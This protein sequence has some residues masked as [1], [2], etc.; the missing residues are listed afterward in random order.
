[1]K[2]KKIKKMLV[3]GT[4][5]LML[6]FTLAGCGASK[7]SSD[8]IAE[9]YDYDPAKV[10]PSDT[11]QIAVLQGS[12]YDMG[13]QLGEQFKDEVIA[14]T[15]YLVSGQIDT[16]GSYDAAVEAFQPYLEEADKHFTHEKDGGLT[17]MIQGT[18]DSTGMSFDDTMMLYIDAASDIPANTPSG[19]G[20]GKTKEDDQ[21]DCSATMIWGN[22]TATDEEGCIGSMK[23]DIG[24]GDLNFMPTMLMIPDNGNAFIST[25]GVFGSAV[26]EKG[27][28]VQSPGGSVV[29]YDEVY[30]VGIYPSMYL[31]AYCDTTKEAIKVLGDPETT[32]RE[33]WW[34]IGTDFNMILG[35][36]KGDACVFEISGSERNIRYNGE[37]KYVGKTDAG[38]A[39]VANETADYLCAANY[40]MSDNMLFTSRVNPQVGLDEAWPDGLVRYWSLEKHIQ[41]AVA[42]GGADEEILRKAMSSYSYYIP[43]GWDY[44]AYPD[45]GYYGVIVP[46]DIYEGFADGSI[47][48]ED[49]YGKS[50][51]PEMWGEAM[52]LEESR[53]AEDW[54]AGWHDNLNGEWTWNLDT[55]YWAP[56]PVTPDNKTGLINIFDSNSKTLY[57]QKGS[58]DR[59]LSNIPD[60]TGTFAALQFADKETVKEYDGDKA[61]A[62]LGSMQYEL[63]EQLWFAARDLTERGVDPDTA[64]GKIQYGYLEDAKEM[65]YKAQSYASLGNIAKDENEKLS[66]YSKAMSEYVKGQCYAKMAQTDSATLYKDYGKEEPSYR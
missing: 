23:A 39:V 18:A 37:T 50:Y 7:G 5:A 9:R 22:A 29:N 44:D 14:S 63:E 53:A 42:D 56:E 1:M 45:Y 33:D 47:S 20:E 26:N 30:R 11:S 28:M 46:S 49:Y 36:A 17:D 3:C 25:H 60:S 4:T 34:P 65:I 48:R 61:A 12:W 64:T 8:E 27:F 10:T 62:M 55:S 66:Y 2:N 6:G 58:S 40:Y 54:S 15:V 41:E 13:Y 19:T 32:D 43:E 31:A 35:D 38:D 59:A 52:S 24:Y 16:W 57:I 21:K 51:D